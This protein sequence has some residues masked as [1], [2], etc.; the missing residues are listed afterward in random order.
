M[1]NCY[2]RLSVTGGLLPSARFISLVVH[3]DLYQESQ[4]LMMLPIFG[5]FIDHDLTSTAQPKNI[6]GQVPSCC[7]ASSDL[8]PNCMPIKVPDDDPWLSPLGV[9]CLEFLRS[10]PATRRDCTLSWREQTNQASSYL[11]ASMI[12]SSNIQLSDNSRLFRDGLL[13]FGKG[14]TVNDICRNGGINSAC[15][16][17]GDTRSAEQP[18]LLAM[19]TIFVSEHNRVALQLSDLNPHW[20]DEKLYQEAR[21]IIGAMIQHITYHEFLPLVLGREVMQLF[22]L[23]VRQ[24]GFYDGYDPKVNP[25]VANAFSTAA[26]RFGHSMIQSTLMR[27]DK[28]HNFIKN[29]VSLHEENNR[30]D[31]GGPGSLHRLLRG[32]I[33]QQ[34]ARGDEFL[35]AELT[36]HLFQ[37]SRM[38]PTVEI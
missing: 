35:S 5:Q 19:H 14:G 6:N 38:S 30:G 23:K 28:N 37:T 10:A 1:I 2:F 18:G 13:V 4:V 34:A 24:T 7:Q 20:S 11:D 16:K 8:H 27:S 15:V 31:M 12:Y 17:A 9:R 3:G 22:D 32:M 26:F 21:R 25:T 29:N 33:N 36:N